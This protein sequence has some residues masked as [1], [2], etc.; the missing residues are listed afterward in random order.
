MV[1]LLIGILG[2][3]LILTAFAMNEWKQ[4]R[5]NSKYYDIFN[6]VGALLLGIYAYLIGSIPFLIL[7]AIWFIVAVRDLVL[8]MKK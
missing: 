5:A 3:I 4:W 2:M 7:N 1:I 8:R 6:A